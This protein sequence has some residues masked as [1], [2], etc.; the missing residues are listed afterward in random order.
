MEEHDYVYQLRPLIIPG[1]IF[2]ILYPLIVGG[3]HAFS[4]LPALE[5]RVLIGIYVISGLGIITLWVVGKSKRIIINGNQIVFR[6]LLGERILE[7]KDIRRVAFYFDD[8]GQEIAQIRTSEDL[9]YVSEFY[10]P[11]PELMSDLEIF[12][13][14]YDIRSNLSRYAN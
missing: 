10:F 2:L 1:L 9:Y 11:F 7:P 5:L 4:K 12:I 6:S 8:K 14:Q 13:E 3:I